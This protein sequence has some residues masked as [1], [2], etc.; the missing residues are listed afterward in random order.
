MKRITT[1]EDIKVGDIILLKRFNQKVSWIDSI[2]AKEEKGGEPYLSSFSIRIKN[3][4]GIITQ[5]EDLVCIFEKDFL[6]VFNNPVDDDLCAYFLK[7]EEQEKYG[8]IILALKIK[9]DEE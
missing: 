8:K 2:T 4:E 6:I 5:N 1:I 3:E 7:E 9:G